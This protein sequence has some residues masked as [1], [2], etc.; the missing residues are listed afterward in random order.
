LFAGILLAGAQALAISGSAFAAE[1]GAG[2]VAP[3][4]V[5]F[6]VQSL[7]GSRNNLANP[8]WGQANTPYSRV[9][10][11]R[12]A[13]GRSQPFGGP[14]S[15]AVSNRVFN[16]S[17]QNLFSER[18]ITA[19]GWT[20]GQ[21]LDHTFGLRLGRS[22]GDPAGQP[23]NIPFNPNDPLEEFENDLGVI[24]FVRSDA[25]P[26]TGVN[27]PRQQVNTNSSYIDAFAV[28]GGTNTR[29]DW[30]REGS[31]DG[32]PSNN[33]ARLLLQNDYLPR[34]DARGN[35]AAAPAMEVDGILRANPNQAMVAGD[36]RANE[37]LFLT[38]THT[39]F[40]REHNRIVN[41]LPSTLSQED[42]FQ[43]ARRVIIAQQQFIT[44]NE[45]L[46]A[47]G[48]SLPAYTGYKS[49]V[50]AALSNEFATVG[51]RVHSMIHGEM[52]IAAE[53][54]RYT[55]E[56]LA[57]FRAQGIDVIEEEGEVELV[58]PLNKG[59]FNPNL[60]PA[61]GL[62]PLLA[63]IGGEA[64]YKNEEMIDN[65]LRSVLFQIPVSGNPECLD[66]PTLPECF[67]GVVDLGAIDVERG[68]DHGMPTYN[69]LR[70]A[71]G[72]P[73]RT[74][75]TQITGESSS[76]FPPGTGIDDPDSLRF[77]RLTDVFNA[78]VDPE[79]EER[80]EGTPTNFVRG[81]PLAARLQAIYGNVNNVD[82][83]VG[84][85]AERHASNGDLGELQR[86]I[87]TREFTRLRDGDRF[88]FGNDAALT[89]IRNQYGI[90]FRASLG[91]LIGRN[92]DVPRAEL[93]PN[94]FFNGG[95]VPPTSCRVSYAIT[96]QWSN[97]FRATMSITNTG[98]RPL[99]NWA[100][101]FTFANGQQI[102]QLWNGVVVQDGFRVPVTNAAWN[103][104]LAPGQ[105]VQ[106][107]G[108]VASW[109]GVRNNR[110]TA[111]SVNTTPCSIG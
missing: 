18:Q 10:P 4:A 43:I 54:D 35:P 47:M 31:V 63:G 27:N 75:F 60:V 110:P 56:Q 107:V 96:D 41:A 7:D 79:D 22:P 91:D 62:G 52:E 39:L 30:L 109:N 65:Q 85:V 5:P 14:N 53:A 13:D 102:S 59:F 100:L 108:F 29:L 34:R 19:W 48:V 8:T 16:D 105:T 84:A 104:V 94:V 69:Q 67:D 57:A 38:A 23:A 78:V 15:R 3:Q 45:W 68:R 70:Q 77:N 6:E 76:S 64:Q 80:A 21:F 81:A 111:F 74:S 12:Y 99:N 44:Y 89:Q 98:T 82:A 32:N 46:P 25:A 92:T 93:N 40:A 36:V 24:S 97:G 20:W 28:Y 83:F 26:G 33:S 58:I 37:N 49:N 101:R 9:A 103:A 11:A 51:Y 1:E 55:P 106:D 87:W 72:L 50:N 73:A 95:F 88:F 2:G 61:I 66:G 17:N 90:D 71:Y 42:K 86:A